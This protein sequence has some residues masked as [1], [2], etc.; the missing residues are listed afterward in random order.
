MAFLFFRRKNSITLI[1]LLTNPKVEGSG[2]ITGENGVMKY[3]KC[4]ATV[5]NTKLVR[6][7]L[8]ASATAVLCVNASTHLRKNNGDMIQHYANVLSSIM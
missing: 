4:S 8:E 2:G 1:R 5:N 6:P 3:S 7:L